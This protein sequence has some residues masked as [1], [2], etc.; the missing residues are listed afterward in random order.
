MSQLYVLTIVVVFIFVHFN[1]ERSI[2]ISLWSLTRGRI[3]WRNIKDFIIS[4]KL[5][6]TCT[7]KKIN[8][9]FITENIIL[10]T[11]DTLYVIN[12]TDILNNYVVPDIIYLD[13]YTALDKRWYM[14][15]PDQLNIFKQSSAFI[16]NCN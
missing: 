11:D 2:C 6:G 5:N 14:F 10:Y 8:N 12:M 13:L 7:C 15:V 4:E 3:F 1:Q 16:I 9:H